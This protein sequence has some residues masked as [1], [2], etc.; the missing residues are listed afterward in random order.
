LL[1]ILHPYDTI[2]STCYVD[3]DT[4]RATYLTNPNKCHVSHVAIDTTGLSEEDLRKIDRMVMNTRG[5]ILYARALVFFEGETEE[6]ALPIF[7]ERYWNQHL[8]NLSISMVGVGGDRS[9]TPFL[10]LAHSFG[11]PWYIFSDGENMR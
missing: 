9:Y 4:T 5:E 2:G 8:S 11:I 10:R 7:A 6:Q 1:P 3:F